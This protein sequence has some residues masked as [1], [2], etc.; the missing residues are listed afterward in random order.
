MAVKG[1]SKSIHTQLAT[2]P[3][4]TTYASWIRLITATAHQQGLRMHSDNCART[5]IYRRTCSGHARNED[6]WY[7][8]PFCQGNVPRFRRI[9]TYIYSRSL[10]VR[11]GACRPC[12][13]VLTS[14][15]HTIRSHSTI[16][17]ALL[18]IHS[19]HNTANF[20]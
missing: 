17:Q 15:L 4:K 7:G 5:C 3:S 13:Y 20:K 11:A 1:T 18:S 9:V 12:E 10:P 6:K 2:E 19:K 14:N 16:Q 8:Q